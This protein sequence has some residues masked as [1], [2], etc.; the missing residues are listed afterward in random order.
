MCDLE[1]NSLPFHDGH[2]TFVKAI[3]SLQH[4]SRNGARHVL[5]ETY[6]ILA[7]DGRFYIMLGD[8]RFICERILEDGPY[9]GWLCCMFH[10]TE[11]DPAFGFH[12]WAWTIESIQEDLES[13]GFTDVSFLGYYNK[14]EFRMQ[15]FKR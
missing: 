14:W 5:E 10:G 2:A 15:A 6:R 3:H 9:E 7:P 12:K 8:L 13:A 1:R 11:I 4:M